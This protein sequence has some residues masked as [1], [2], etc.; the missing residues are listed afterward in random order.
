MRNRRRSRWFLAFS[1]LLAAGLLFLAFRGVN[2]REI[3]ETIRGARVEYLVLGSIIGGL[4][5]FVRGLRWRVMLSAE[6]KIAPLTVFWAN[7]VGYLG[8]SFLPARAGEVI[9]SVMLGHRCS[10]SKSY[11]LATA[12]TER[13]LDAVVL[14]IV[15]SVAFLSLGALPY[16]LFSSARGVGIVGLIA[17]VGLIVVPRF[18]PLLGRALRLLPFPTRLRPRALSMMHDFVRGMRALHHVRRALSFGSLTVVIWLMDGMGAMI[19]ARALNLTLSLPQALIL[20]AA[21]GLSSMVPSTPGY[22][23]VYQIVA[24][25]VLPAF[26]FSRSEALAYI[27]VSQ[28]LYYVVVTILGLL[29]LWRLNT[30][31][32][33]HDS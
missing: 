5:F 26:G 2:W 7:M 18:E 32:V 13:L 19:G 15:G 21:L 28:A 3:L 27:I 31:G 4:C 17:L 11:V 30:Q 8:N 20:L 29:G 6:K 1:L 16:S 25:A 23:G 22:V 14:V 10:I 33:G 9:R 24:V 12:L